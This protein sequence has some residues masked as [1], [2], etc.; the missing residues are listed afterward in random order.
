MIMQCFG[1]LGPTTLTRHWKTPFWFHHTFP[2]PILSRASKHPCE[3][4]IVQL[5]HWP[6]SSAGPSLRAPVPP[7]TTSKRTVEFADDAT[8]DLTT[9][10]ITGRRSRENHLML[11]T[12]KAV[13]TEDFK[14][15]ERKGDIEVNDAEW[16]VGLGSVPNTR[17]SN[18]RRGRLLYLVSQQRFESGS[19][20]GNA[21][22][23]RVCDLMFSLQRKPKQ[24][25]P[26]PPPQVVCAS[27]YIQK[28]RR[29]ERRDPVHAAA[30]FITSAFGS[31]LPR[32]LSLVGA[33]F[34]PT[35]KRARRPILIRRHTFNDPV[36]SERTTASQRFCW[37]A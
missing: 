28:T 18:S 26:P 22:T 3:G 5:H 16:P 13:V 33:L 19:E 24:R 32:L 35:I 8:K 9:G 15:H 20:R 29:N 34:T 6:V 37:G 25:R 17:L 14:L 36:S 21:L 10:L 11:N 2:C 30:A 31:A 12:P 27:L 23:Q 1:R 4:A 7:A